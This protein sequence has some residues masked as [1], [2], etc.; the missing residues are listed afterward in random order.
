M[1]RDDE[2]AGPHPRSQSGKGSCSRLRMGGAFLNYPRLPSR[3][4]S[5]EISPA[6]SSLD[7]SHFCA[8]AIKSQSRWHNSSAVARSLGRQNG[9]CDDDPEWRIALLDPA[10]SQ[11]EP[12]GRRCCDR[13]PQSV[14]LRARSEPS[15]A[16]GSSSR[17][18]TMLSGR[19][20]KNNNK[21]TRFRPRVQLVQCRQR[22]LMKRDAPSLRLRQPGFR[23]GISN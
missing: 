11:G 23:R 15:A 22:E 13:L 17:D 4:E 10:S 7:N 14:T 3:H 21:N 18:F 2:R 8:S 19:A 16:V 6:W 20:L 1:A 12:R 9:E 5:P